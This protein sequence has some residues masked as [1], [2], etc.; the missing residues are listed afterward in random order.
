MTHYPRTQYYHIIDRL[1]NIYN[2][3]GQNQFRISVMIFIGKLKQDLINL[4][5]SMNDIIKNNNKSNKI[6]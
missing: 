2:I 1:L 6:I 3:R 4:G 5:I